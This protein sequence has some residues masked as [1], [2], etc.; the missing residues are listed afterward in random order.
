ME[1]YNKKSGYSFTYHEDDLSLIK[2]FADEKYNIV[3]FHPPLVRQILTDEN[4]DEIAGGKCNELPVP[5]ITEQKNYIYDLE[6][7]YDYSY[8]LNKEGRENRTRKLAADLLTY[9]DTSYRRT[10]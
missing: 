3:A 4:I 2:E 6:Y 5:Y 8:H 9:I 7:I 10:R 1:N